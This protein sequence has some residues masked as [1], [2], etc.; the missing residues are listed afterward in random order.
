MEKYRIIICLLVMTSVYG[1]NRE[2]IFHDHEATMRMIMQI[3]TRQEKGSY[4]RTGDGDINLANGLSSGTHTVNPALRREMQE[5][6]LMQGPNILR[7]LPVDLDAY[8]SEASHE[9][10]YI[11]PQ[12]VTNLLA[13][14]DRVWGSDRNV[15]SAIFLSHYAIVDADRAIAFLKF[16]KQSHCSLLIGN[17]HIP[18]DVVNLLF[19]KDCVHIKTPQENPYNAI[20]QIEQQ[21]LEAI[22]ALD[23]SRYHVVILC[24]G[25]TGRVLVKRMY[26]KVGQHVFFF[27]FGSLIDAISGFGSRVWIRTFFDRAM[28]VEKLQQALAE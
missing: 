16:L 21:S 4:F 8:K 1:D 6:L 25:N 19:G 2:F 13:K 28:F 20:D 5:A 14:A 23:P 17:D 18:S 7:S 9:P 15:Y 22:N 26:E 11:T 10:Y 12:Y 24:V 27:D 3:I